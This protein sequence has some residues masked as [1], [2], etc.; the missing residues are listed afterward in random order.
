MSRFPGDFEMPVHLFGAKSSP[1]CASFALRRV[2]DGTAIDPSQ[3]AVYAVKTSFYVHDCVKSVDSEDIAIK[4]TDEVK[5][6][7]TSGGFT[8]T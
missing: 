3:E 5:L 1:T 8:L 7:L 2:A 4:L 6:L